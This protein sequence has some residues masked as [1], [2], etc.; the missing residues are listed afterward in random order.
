MSQGQKKKPLEGVRVLELGAFIGGPFGTRI[1]A[2][3]GAEVIKVEPPQS[4]DPMRLWGLHKYKG[5]SLWWPIQSRNKKCI[6]LDLRRKAGQKLALKLISKC[7]AVVENFRPGILEKWNL[8]YD[9]MRTVNPRIILT[10]VSGY[11]QTGPYRQK[12]GFGSIAEAIGG[13]R[14]ITGYPDLPPTRVGLSIGD[15]L[16]ALYAVIGTLMALYHRDVNKSGQGQVIDVA[17]YEAVFSVME[18]AL[19]EYDKLGFIRERYGTG[20]PGIAPS[21]TYP[22]GDGKWIVIGANADNVWR[23]LARAMGQQDLADD[24]RFVDHQSRGEH[25][26]ILDDIISVWTRQHTLKE[27]LE[28]LDRHQVPAGPIYSVA[29]I[30]KDKHYYHREMILEAEDPVVGRI[31]MPGIVPKLSET[32]GAVEWT[33]PRLGEHNQEIYGDLLGLNERK[34]DDLRKEGVI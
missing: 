19:T 16:A 33:G 26:Q 6:T 7:D 22:T 28:S 32:P 30:A 29:D 5:H 27:L 24:P 25:Q 14:Y 31:K 10:R 34:I 4:G 15:S 1:L 20:L 3:F 12:A 2:D 17:L 13:I 9:K 11:G 18:S 8:G 23:R 21:N